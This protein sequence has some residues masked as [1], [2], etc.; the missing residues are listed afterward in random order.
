MQVNI[1]FDSSGRLVR[2][3]ER[4]GIPDMSTSKGLKIEQLDS[5]IRAQEAKTRSTTVSLDYGIDQGIAMNRGGGKPTKAV[6]GTVREIE[7]MD[8]LGPTTARLERVRKLCGV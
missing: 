4:R 5:L 3:S 7:Q 2:Y 1:T 8:K 6:I